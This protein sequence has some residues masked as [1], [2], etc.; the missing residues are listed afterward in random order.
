GMGRH[1][2][3]GLLRRGTLGRAVRL[4]GGRPPIAGDRP[5]VDGRWIQHSPT[6]PGSGKPLWIWLSVRHIAVRWHNA[7][8]RPPRRQLA[9]S[10]CWRA[11]LAHRAARSAAHGATDGEPERPDR[12]GVLLEVAGGAGPEA[13]RTPQNHRGTLERPAGGC[14]GREDPARRG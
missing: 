7:R 14:D 3:T 13:G 9:R 11:N 12:R 2:A 6:G 4:A 10:P 1:A 5:S 8:L